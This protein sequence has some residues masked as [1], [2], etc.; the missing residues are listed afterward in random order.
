MKRIAAV[1]LL[2]S[3]VSPALARSEPDEAVRATLLRQAETLRDEEE[4]T[5][6]VAAE[7]A[8]FDQ[9]LAELSAEEGRRRAELT[10]LLAALE[11]LSRLPPAA[12]VSRPE[13][14]EAVV[15]GGLLMRSAVPAISA[16][17]EILRAQLAEVE[18]LR[19]LRNQTGARLIRRQADLAA[20]E[21][22]TRA[23]VARRQATPPPVDPALARRLAEAAKDAPT[24]D[25]LTVSLGRVPLPP[26]RPPPIPAAVAPRDL[27]RTDARPPEPAPAPLPERSVAALPATAQTAATAPKIVWDD[28]PPAPRAIDPNKRVPPVVAPVSVAFG[29][30]DAEGGTAKGVWYRPRAGATVVAPRAGTVAFAAA[31]GNYGETVILTHDGGYNSILAQL[32]RIDV[33]NG[34]ELAAGEPIGTAAVGDAPTLYFEYRK[35]GRPVDPAP[36]FAGRRRR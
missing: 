5:A 32:G 27:P 33:S 31:Y 26:R 22:E 30:R 2:L 3:L 29:R 35:N 15:N 23:L 25:R 14:G 17:I 34:Q 18:R 13:G 20:A 7:L 28:P 16:R 6:G 21:A 10:R 24:L 9:R 12:I 8:A 19:A 36:L 4:A 11:R 1:L